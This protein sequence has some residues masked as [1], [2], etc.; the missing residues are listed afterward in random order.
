[1]FAKCLFYM[2]RSDGVEPPTYWFVVSE[3]GFYAALSILT[4]IDLS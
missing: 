4:T 2:V 1:M 3:S